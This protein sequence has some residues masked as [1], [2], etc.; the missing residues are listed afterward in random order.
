MKLI[1][2]LFASVLTLA[3]CSSAGN[4]QSTTESPTASDNY[5]T[6]K[7]YYVA[8]TGTSLRLYSELAFVTTV[9]QSPDISSVNALLSGAQPKDPDYVNLWGEGVRINN[10]L[11]AGEL[12]TVDI[13][14]P[15]LNVGAEAEARAIDQVIWTF[16][17]A[18]PALSSFQFLINGEIVETL[19][20]HVD[21]SKPIEIDEG[22][23]SLATIDL[24]LDQD[25][26]LKSPIV[27]TGL[28][29]TFE[30]NAPWE[31]RR[32]GE[33]INFGAETAKEACPTRS[34]FEINLGEL[35][36]GTY[37]IRVWESSMEDGSLI[38]EDT[39]TFTV[40]DELALSSATR[41]AISSSKS[42]LSIFQ[43]TGT[44]IVFLFTL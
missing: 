35:V 25:Q 23:R 13:Q 3:G 15:H 44:W 4:Q 19:A 5:Q 39:K 37:E 28:A 34:V 9:E 2:I 30:A 38:N 27:L 42:F 12:D 17:S 31:L 43:S 24:D 26:E 33:L 18:I 36:P 6:V 14:P 11:V 22:F 10:L 29:C 8:D 21:I 7:I 40:I 1:S 16:K 32:N 20:G 41:A